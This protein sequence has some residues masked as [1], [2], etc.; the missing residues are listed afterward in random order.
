MSKLFPVGKLTRAALERGKAP[1]GTGCEPASVVMSEAREG[2]IRMADPLTPGQPQE[3][4][5]LRDLESSPPE[6]HTAN[7]K[8]GRDCDRSLR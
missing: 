4:E 8:E 1:A 7:S 3:R 6:S 5:A 2:G